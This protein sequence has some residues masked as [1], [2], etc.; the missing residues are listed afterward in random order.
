MVGNLRYILGVLKMD[1]C[2]SFADA[3]E[4]TMSS[5]EQLLLDVGN[6]NLI[7]SGDSGVELVE[8]TLKKR[9]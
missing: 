4:A 5:C 8:I 6:L 7:A 9:M 1:F 2:S 3:C